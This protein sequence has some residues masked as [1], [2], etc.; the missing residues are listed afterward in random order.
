ML[1]AASKMAKGMR[2]TRTF[3]YECILLKIKSIDYYKLLRKWKILPLPAISTIYRYL[4]KMKASY[5]FHEEIFSVIQ[6]KEKS[7]HANNRRG[8]KCS[9]SYFSQI[10]FCFCEK[11]CSSIYFTA[12]QILQAIEEF[13]AYIAKCDEKKLTIIRRI[14]HVLV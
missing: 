2:Y 3:M 12:L 14:K 1:L 6:I 8:K 7:M 9:F 13:L 4:G 10:I 11:R 5:G